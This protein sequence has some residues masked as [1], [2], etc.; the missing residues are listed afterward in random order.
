MVAAKIAGSAE[1][2][3]VTCVNSPCVSDAIHSQPR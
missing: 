2:G 3:H 1:G